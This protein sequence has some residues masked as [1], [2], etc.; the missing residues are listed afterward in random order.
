[1][2]TEKSLLVQKKINAGQSPNDEGPYYHHIF[3]ESY[4]GGV[5]GKFGGVVIGSALGSVV[6]GAMLAVGTIAGITAITAAPAL[7]VVGAFSAAG[8]LYGAHEFG[9]V[10]KAVGSD[11]ALGQQ[12]EA[13]LKTYH[14][15]KTAELKKEINEL[16]SAV[17][18]Q[19]V[20]N[21][22]KLDE[23]IIRAEEDEHNY[24][25][26]HY[27]KL[28]P[29]PVNS[30]A[31]WKV[32]L[33]GLVVGAAV[34]VLF[35][36]G[37]GGG[38]AGALLEHALGHTL[39]AGLAEGGLMAASA[40]TFG[41]MGATFG[42]NRDFFRKIFDK[43]DLLFKGIISNDRVKE[44]QIKA[45]EA[46]MHKLEEAKETAAPAPEFSVAYPDSATHHR[47][48]LALAAERSLANMDQTRMI[49]H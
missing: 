2:D 45:G 47:D 19:P 24:R 1:M 10:G 5:K 8:G 22:P 7:L 14:E 43:T 44:Q 16:K 9:D 28:E 32:A 38:V 36:A 6:G 3:W 33:V 15:G 48:K 31:F 17:T 27:A 46:I 40:A 30:L 23:A 11:A 25:K 41:L 21:D 34:G 37:P 42:I 20:V 35:A 29:T 26:V 39:G 49:P 4:K 12:L 13:R 18:G